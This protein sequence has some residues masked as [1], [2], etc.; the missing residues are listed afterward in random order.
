MAEINGGSLK[1]TAE[2]DVSGLKKAAQ[3]GNVSLSKL[4][5]TATKTGESIDDAFGA[6]KENIKIQ[7]EVILDL[8]NQYKE[9]QKTIDKI[10]PGQAKLNL[11]GDAA[12]IAKE[13][14]VEKKALIEL[15]TFVK[16]NQET[17]ESLRQKLTAVKSE[18]QE[19]AVAGKRDSI[20]YDELSKKA[21]DY[22]KAIDEVNGTMKALGGN[23]GL[24]ALV[25][26]LG[27]ASGAMATF[28]GLSAMSAG[29][30]ERLDQIMVKLQS[31]MSIAIGIQQIQNSLQKESGV[32]QSVMALQ[33]M[34]R[35]RAEK[36]ATTNTI[37]ST[38]A[39]RVFNA[40]AKANPYVLLA[41]ALITV[42]GALVLF[43]KRTK[44]ARENESALAK[45]TAEGAAE[46]VSSY[47]KLQY[48]WNALG[49]DLKKKEQFI[50]DN[51][52]EFKK[53][54]TEVENVADAENVLI[55]N[56]E[57]F[58]NALMLRARAAAEMQIAQENYKKYLEN[59]DQ[60][61]SNEEKYKG[62]TFGG[63]NRAVDNFGRDYLGIG[64]VSKDTNNSYL[65]TANQ[66]IKDHVKTT[67]KAAQELEKAKIKI[68]GSPPAKGSEEWYKS[69][70]ARLEELKSKAIV[71]SKEWNSY[72]KQIENYQDLINPKKAKKTK[73]EKVD[74]F[75]PPGSV[76]EIQKRI[77]E[78]DN[79]LSKATG[80]KQIA[81]L[82]N[83]RIAIAKELAE[84]EK[85]IQILSIQEQLDESN[86][87][88][89]EYYSTVES[90]GKN[91]ADNIYGDLLKEGKSQFDQ[92]VKLHQELSE[93]SAKGTLTSEEKEVYVQATQAIDAMLGRQSALEKFNSDIQ[94][95]LSKMTTA[96]ERLKFLQDQLAGLNEDDKSNGKYASLE[97]LKR[98]EIDDQKRQYQDLL[99]Q[100]Q[101]FEDKRNE[102]A[103]QASE[104]RIQILNDENLTPERKADLTNK[105]TKE[106]NNATSAAALEELQNSDV[107]QTLNEN[108]DV[109]TATQIENLLRILDEK[110][111]ELAAKMTPMDFEKVKQNL[112][113]ARQQLLNLNPFTGMLSLA[114]KNLE[115]F[116]GE[117]G[118]TGEESSS[119]ENTAQRVSNVA[120]KIKLATK[121][122][123]PFQDILGE[124][125]SEVLSTISTVATGAIVMVEQIGV[126][127]KATSEGIKKAE[128]GSVILAILQIVMMAVKMIISLFSLFS[129]D[130][131]KEK[132]IK[133]WAN[134]VENL[135]NKYDELTRAIEGSAQ[136]GTIEAQRKLID[137]LREQQR[138]LKQMKSAEA[139][140][141]KADAGK[142]N[143]LNGQIQDVN[144][145]IED[146][147]NDFKDSVIT[148]DLRSLSEDIASSLVEAFGK[149]E[150]AA[151][152]FEKTV[153]DVMRNAVMNALRIK[154]LQP[155]IEEMIDKLYSSMGY[156]NS[157]SSQTQSQITDLEKELAQVQKDLQNGPS[158]A[159][160]SLRAKEMLL[161]K[162]LERL[163]QLLQNQSTGGSFDGLTDAER[164]EIKAMG[165]GAMEQ[166][167]A[168]LQQYE[169][170]FGSASTNA[171]SLSGA[172]KGIT[173]ETASILAGQMNAI[174][175][176]QGEALNVN[177]ESQNVLRNQL[178]QLTQ[179]EINTRYLKGIY[180]VLNSQKTLDLRSSG[181]V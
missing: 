58:L 131:K 165:Q 20:Q 36:L 164:E 124:T 92:L 43:S 162:E 50:K 82:K 54:G 65:T 101:S 12:G 166:Y 154:I 121:A 66:K 70:I 1:Y 67:E 144:N 145:K 85:K 160:G 155:A 61:D 81:E 127:V 146:L 140:K 62:Q 53:L 151:A 39:Q 90:L 129:G 139:D 89:S 97:E 27:L 170:L 98:N 149:G 150:D 95:S 79:A 18:M 88:W 57:S 167:M 161:K 46:S 80:D 100:H 180:M 63:I 15:E 71:G 103:K 117:L 91:V 25:Q 55:K 13:I 26:T 133:A 175:I 47:K 174:R 40:V 168:A 72:K 22:Q 69:E 111:P 2:L 87:L 44:D 159:N 49:N 9:L 125:G 147:V 126:V 108:L 107:W 64:G 41:T 33:A 83:K 118:K 157:Q 138:L 156:G 116:S 52:D 48:Q 171:S 68:A 24:N 6:T 75:F 106:Q 14:E 5:D 110:A 16:S 51:K 28:Q 74:E 60:V 84:A 86:K 132:A 130:K 78:I 3:E 135:K 38:V 8:E 73:K 45:A 115:E 42:V 141:K 109:L 93:K 143:D 19:L 128:M 158:Y 17:H 181:L 99:L 163:K 148:T 23:T 169:D 96:T 178:L 119:W 123:E 153:D 112:R 172:I 152:A 120:G 173:E 11:M 21:E 142:I 10:A 76:G 34:A 114:R 122:L 136:E 113:S 29:E 7:K 35:A 177:R 4:S 137:N 179:I 176:M 59:K 94:F 30:N 102:I 32:I 56:T 104:Q 134:E 77:A 37:A 31:T 105:I